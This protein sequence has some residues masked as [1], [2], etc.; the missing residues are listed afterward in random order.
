MNDQYFVSITNREF[1]LI[2]T[3]L[4]VWSEINFQKGHKV[5]NLHD[6]GKP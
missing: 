5:N 2:I 1:T 4:N 3:I 6:Y